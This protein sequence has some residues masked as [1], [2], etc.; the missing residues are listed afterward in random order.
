MKNKNWMMGLVAL[1]ISS[2]SIV[3]KAQEVTPILSYTF[4]QT[5]AV[6]ES[7]NYPYTLHNNAM[8]LPTDDGNRVLSTGNKN[9]Y[10]ELGTSVGSGVLSRLTGDYTISIDLCVDAVNALNRFS[11]AWA[12]TNG[13]GTYLG[14]VNAAGNANWYYEIKDGTAQ[15]VRS[16]SGLTT[17]E[18]HTITVTQ[19]SG[20]ATF[21]LDGVAKGTASLTLKPSDFAA[22]LTGN[23]L[24]RSPFSGDAYMIN[25]LMD[26]FKVYDS[27]LTAEQVTALYE[28]RPQ[29]QSLVMDIANALRIDREDLILSQAATFIHN[30]LRLPTTCSY[31]EVEWSYIPFDEPKGEGRLNY[32]EG[33]FTV[34]ERGE[35]PTEVGTLQGTIT[36]DGNEYPLFEKSLTVRVAPDDNAYGYLYCHMPNLV[37]QTGVG[38]LVSQTITYA[39]GKE[40]DKGLVF[41][42]LN[43]GSAIID[44]IGTKLPWCR[45]AFMA[46]DKKRGCYYIVTTDLY[47]SLDNGTSMLW[48]YSIGMFRSYDMINW[49]YSRCDLKKYLT[50]NPPK[51]IYNNAGTALL[52]AN[53]VSRVWAP[54][55]TFI[56]GTPYIYYA[57]G[58]TDNGDCDHFYISKANEDFTGIESFQMLYGANKVNN[59]L[60]ADLVFLETDSLWHMSY[61]DYEA[62][63]IQD[64]TTKDLLNPVWSAPVSSFVHVGGFEA[65]SVFRR[66][67]DDVWNIG[68][69]NYSGDVGYH[70]KTADAMLRN[71][72]ASPSMTGH[73]SPQHGSF[74]HINET[75]YQLLQAW[76]DLKALIA[77]GTTL[78]EKVKSEQLA[79]LIQKAVTDISTDNG[80]NTDLKALA[81]T[82]QED[83]R[84]LRARYQYEKSLYRAEKTNFSTDETKAG[85]VDAALNNGALTT[86]ITNALTVRESNDPTILMATADQLEAALTQYFETLQAA[87]EKVTVTN[88]TFNTSNTGWTLVSGTTG[89]NSGVAE[90]FA[91][92]A[93]DYSAFITQT[94]RNLDE[95]YYLVKCQAFERNGENDYTGRDCQEGVEQI[96]YK[97]FANKDTVEIQSLYNMPYTG[98]GNLHGFA[99]TMAA[100]NTLFSADATNYANYLLIYVDTKRIK[101]GLLR[102]LATIHSSNWCCFDNFEIYSLGLITDIED[103]RTSAFEEEQPIY[104]LS[105][106][107]CGMTDNNGDLPL[108][109]KKG[110]YIV[111][112]QKVV[113]E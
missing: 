21:Y 94:R 17:D 96:N 46:K 106:V 9:G 13:T 47:G 90:F 41:N 81:Q 82:L 8:V 28:A 33:V 113:K 87:G 60:D 97:M 16:G 50:A 55:I 84:Q 39:L 27:A 19:V 71:L 11:W 77:D 58:N 44:G 56:D 25:T 69:V 29:S 22:T 42:E 1:V 3:S 63:T 92:R 80:A 54:Q 91:F 110:I 51:D 107:Q 66:I 23:Y 101:F 102:D 64:I 14:M 111:N 74:L 6:D 5:E 88:G 31:G 59:V 105:G 57:V 93:V 109:L 43:R 48:N 79:A 75:E 86:S 108:T 49:T 67:N 52:T 73:L 70:F 76:S 99:N 65:S 12:F 32:E 10:L 85:V 35:T 2:L 95:G 62:G 61:R 83:F 20:V 89:H 103:V 68:Y 38:T 45:D 53:K 18:W 7:G 112:H 36:Y 15:S 34:T 72:Q 4:E 40:E 26:N 24:G 37:P 78:N 30:E 104:N 100:A 98:A